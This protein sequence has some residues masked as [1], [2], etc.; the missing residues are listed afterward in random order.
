MACLPPTPHPDSAALLYSP[1][2]LPNF[3]PYNLSR[4]LLWDVL[5]DIN[6]I[7]PFPWSESCTGSLLP[8]ASSASFSQ[9]DPEDRFPLW[10]DMVSLAH[11][12]LKSDPGFLQGRLRTPIHAQGCGGPAS[13]SCPEWRAQFDSMG[14][15]KQKLRIYCIWGKIVHYYR[16]SYKDGRS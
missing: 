16:H 13:Y 7:M 15:R 14:W 3:V 9:T 5:F 4:T 10:E 12:Y 1:K 11:V 8:R 2:E 6:L